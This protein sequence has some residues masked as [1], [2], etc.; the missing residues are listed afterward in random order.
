M[1]LGGHDGVRTH[2]NIT[3]NRIKQ[4]KYTLV[5]S[6][7][8]RQIRDDEFGD[9]CDEIRTHD[10]VTNERN[11]PVTTVQSKNASNAK[12]NGTTQKKNEE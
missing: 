5:R 10:N 4:M 1:N 3:T 9:G 6:S 7:R 11:T 8:A 12:A 2:E